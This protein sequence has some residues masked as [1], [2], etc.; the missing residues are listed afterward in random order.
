MF[1]AGWLKRSPQYQTTPTAPFISRFLITG[2][3]TSD[4][5]DLCRV[6][7]EVNA[8]KPFPHLAFPHF[9]TLQNAPKQRSF[10][11]ELMA[12]CLVNYFGPNVAF[13]ITGGMAILQ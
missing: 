5:S 11:G 10:D 9:L 12:S 1:A 13:R 4:R 3:Y 8:L 6:N 7:F 2:D